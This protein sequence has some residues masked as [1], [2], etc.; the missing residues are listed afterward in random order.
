[1]PPSGLAS[2]RDAASFCRGALDDM[3]KYVKEIETF[4]H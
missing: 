2:L 3:I 4:S 1:M